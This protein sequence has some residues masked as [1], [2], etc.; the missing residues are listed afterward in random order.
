MSD[1]SFAL[2]NAVLNGDVTPQE[3]AAVARVLEV[4][5]DMIAAVDLDR[6]P[7]ELEAELAKDCE[8]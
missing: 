1:D 2:T 3:G 8:P 4:H 6:R 5:A 7:S